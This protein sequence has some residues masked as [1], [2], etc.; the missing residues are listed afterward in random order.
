M[1]LGYLGRTVP[2]NELAQAI[3]PGR[4]GATA[5]GIIHCARKYG[6]SGQAV[7]LDLESLT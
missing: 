5:I 7:R 2:L 6:L 1:A 3:G 4:D